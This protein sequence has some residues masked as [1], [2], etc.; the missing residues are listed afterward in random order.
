MLIAK[1]LG[2]FSL[3]D[4][5]AVKLLTADDTKGPG[6]D[7]LLFSHTNHSGWDVISPESAAQ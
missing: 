4:A 3:V 7:E 1:K 2:G 5:L 6:R